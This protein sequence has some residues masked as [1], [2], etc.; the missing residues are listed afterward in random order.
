MQDQKLKKQNTEKQ[1]DSKSKPV[2][3]QVS[4]DLQREKVP[5]LVEVTY[6]STSLMDESSEDEDEND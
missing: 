3:K 4:R 6:S 5:H 2:E 1:I